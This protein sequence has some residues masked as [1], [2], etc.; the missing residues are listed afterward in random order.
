MGAQRGV[1]QPPPFRE[2]NRPLHRQPAQPAPAPAASPRHSP[3]PEPEAARR[4]R[5]PRRL[6][7]LAAG[8]QRRP[9][10]AGAPPE[11]S[12]DLMAPPSAAA[13]RSET[14][15]PAAAS[16][17]VAAVLPAAP[18]APP[19]C[20]VAGKRTRSLLADSCRMRPR[21]HRW[22]L[23]RLRRPS[24]P[25]QQRTALCV[26]DRRRLRWREGSSR[27]RRRDLQP[28][29]AQA[30]RVVASTASKALVAV[31]GTCL[32]VELRRN[33]ERPCSTPASSLAAA[34]TRAAAAA[35]GFWA[36]LAAL[37]R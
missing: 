3:E 37:Q 28:G 30:H 4:T 27:A 12:S 21:H 10:L 1:R 24:Y 17:S 7:T 29:A 16:A 26:Y 2:G 18:P 8:P 14:Q 25:A 20:M 36:A 34:R 22:R 23:L 5:R 35:D 19:R 32:A 9:E 33:S 11:D 6:A 31:V 13:V 15:A